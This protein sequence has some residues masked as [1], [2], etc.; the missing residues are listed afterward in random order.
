MMKLISR[1]N[2]FA[3]LD[4]LKA[5]Y[6]VLVPYKKGTF[7]FY[8]SYIS[9]LLKTSLSVRHGPLSHSKASLLRPEKKLPKILTRKFPRKNENPLQLWVSKPAICKAFSFKIRFF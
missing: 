2:L 8:Q 3:L 4:G 6:D 5:D 1:E 9:H 7:R